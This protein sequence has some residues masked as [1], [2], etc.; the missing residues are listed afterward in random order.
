MQAAGEHEQ[1]VGAG[2][3]GGRYACMFASFSH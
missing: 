2:G 1:Q 3:I